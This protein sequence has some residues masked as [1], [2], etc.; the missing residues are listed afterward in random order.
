MPATEDIYLSEG[1]CELPDTSILPNMWHLCIMCAQPFSLQGDPLKLVQHYTDHYKNATKRRLSCEL[2]ALPDGRKLGF[3]N[4]ELYFK[5]L[6]IRPDNPAALSNRALCY[7]KM[8]DLE[9][10]LQVGGGWDN[11]DME[12]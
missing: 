12:G 7:K 3:R 5:H 11:W 9:A 4:V 8:G 2:C 6:E 10:A 1:F